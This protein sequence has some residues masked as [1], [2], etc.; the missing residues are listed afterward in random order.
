MS[1]NAGEKRHFVDDDEW[2]R[3]MAERLSNFNHEAAQNLA[4][5]FE[6]VSP[7][8]S[9][10]SSP[11]GAM[12]VE[13]QHVNAGVVMNAPAVRKKRSKYISN[14]CSECKLKK[15]KC[16]DVRPCAMCVVAGTSDKCL[17]ES[18]N[19]SLSTT[20]HSLREAFF[21]DLQEQ[22]ASLR[23]LKDASVQSGVN[24]T[25]VRPL[26]ELG[27]D[28]SVLYKA[29]RIL[30]LDLKVAMDDAVDLVRK[31][32]V[33]NLKSNPGFKQI[34]TQQQELGRLSNFWQ[35]ND[36]AR[37]QFD[38]TE[39]CFDQIASDRRWGHGRWLSVEF[40][41]N[42]HCRR[43]RIGDDVA[44]LL[45]Y[46]HSEILSRFFCHDIVHSMSEYEVLVAWTSVLFASFSKEA[47]WYMRVATSDR[48][49]EK[50]TLYLKCNLHKSFDQQGRQFGYTI[51]FDLASLEDF[52][53][54]K[55]R[56]L[57]P[58]MHAKGRE[59]LEDRMARESIVFMRKLRVSAD[60]RLSH[61]TSVVKRWVE[62]MKSTHL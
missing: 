11:S 3:L 7:D 41:S 27:F 12:Y 36:A 26:W 37:W 28:V 62:E 10:G 14:S 54:Y 47:V 35:Q 19:V 4:R 23:S 48:Y 56:F 46:H 34:L 33:S 44:D 52:R 1:A 39:D 51:V 18:R 13:P 60:D 49:G 20:I 8:V 50:R 24:I 43:M 57:P 15:R 61:L 30:P 16:S 42:L 2:C 22:D 55:N 17:S 25:I 38:E 31:V 21:Q 6:I 45:G 59:D 58:A 5:T 29:F 9:A 40:D 53:Q 32:M